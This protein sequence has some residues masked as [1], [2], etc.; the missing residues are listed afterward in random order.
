MR[1]WA[2]LVLACACSAAAPL[3]AVPSLVEET[4]GGVYTVRDDSG[5]WGGDLSESVTH[6]SSAPYAA[7]KILDMSTVSDA[8]W[9]RVR[10]VRLS[11]H[12]MV[13]DYSWHD[14]P[15]ANGLDEAVQFVINGHVHEVPT[16]RITPVFVEGTAPRP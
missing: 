9:E 8:D 3:R 7:R 12:L 6:Q 13:R 16:A 11:A 4:A 14:R 2:R 10:E 15:P 1:C 5:Q